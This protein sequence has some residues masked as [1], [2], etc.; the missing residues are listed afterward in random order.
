[1][2]LAGN[3]AIHANWFHDL[4]YTPAQVGIVG[5]TVTENT[6]ERIHPLDGG[7]FGD[8]FQLWGGQFGT[9]ASSNVLIENNKIH[10]NDIPGALYPTHGLKVARS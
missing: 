5:G 1:M 8:A 2:G 4:Q 9:A 6:F 10:F 7:P 3:L